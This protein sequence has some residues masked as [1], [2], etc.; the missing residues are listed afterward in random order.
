MIQNNS[1]IVYRQ[2]LNKTFITAFNGIRYFFK[3]ERNG[4]IQACV[5]AL[6]ILAGLYFRLSSIEW[7]FI[8][9]C[10]GAVLGLEM[11]NSALEHICNLVHKEYHPVIKTIK[12]VSAGAVLLVS[13]ISVLVGLIIFLPKMAALL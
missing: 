13:I 8:L 12:D 11:I 2:A 7:I 3:T 10:I 5:A 4:K 6:V 1:A 9:L